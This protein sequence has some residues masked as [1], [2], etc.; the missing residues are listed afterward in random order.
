MCSFY[1]LLSLSLLPKLFSSQ[2]VCKIIITHTY[3][4]PNIRRTFRSFLLYIL[5]LSI[6]ILS[7]GVSLYI[8]T[9]LF[10][11][12]SAIQIGTVPALHPTLTW[13]IW[14]IISMWSKCFLRDAGFMQTYSQP[15]QLSKTHSIIDGLPNE[16]L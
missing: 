3:S 10:I 15:A 9:E 5:S 4:Q 11:G 8:W 1:F 16:V 7:Y 14:F 2:F 13:F 12:I 6:L